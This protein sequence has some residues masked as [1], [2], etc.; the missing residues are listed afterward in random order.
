MTGS[1]W[2]IQSD[3][4]ALQQVEVANGEVFSQQSIGFRFKYGT[5]DFRNPEEIVHNPEF[6][7]DFAAY[8]NIAFLN[9][10]YYMTIQ[11]EVWKTSEI[12]LEE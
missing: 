11:K 10:F 4:S 8:R 2:I 6:P 12:L 5:N 7:N 3:S 9:G 1:N